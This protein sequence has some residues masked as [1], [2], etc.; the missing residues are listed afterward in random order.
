MQIQKKK[1][2][3]GPNCPFFPASGPA[4][5]CPPMD[6]TT[7]PVIYPIPAELGSQARLG[8]LSTGVGDHPGTARCCIHSFFFFYFLVLSL[9]SH[10]TTLDGTS[11]FTTFLA[12][13][14]PNVFIPT[15]W[16]PCGP[17]HLLIYG[18]IKSTPKR[19]QKSPFLH[20]F[21]AIPPPTFYAHTC[22]NLVG[23]SD[24]GLGYFEFPRSPKKRDFSPY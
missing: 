16:Q 4:L 20:H 10:R 7:P 8:P 1:T 9:N 13:P 12:I 14:S 3:T 17:S 11:F 23:L 18:G 5:F 24:L 21:L 19:P 2:K 22:G 15:V 6:T